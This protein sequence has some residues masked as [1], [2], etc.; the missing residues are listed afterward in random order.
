M[1][2]QRSVKYVEGWTIFSKGQRLLTA[3]SQPRWPAEH[4]ACVVQTERAHLALSWKG[5]KRGK[6]FASIEEGWVHV[7]SVHRV[8]T[9]THGGYRS[10]Q[11]GLQ[12]CLVSATPP[13]TRFS[14]TTE[15]VNVFIRLLPKMEHGRESCHVVGNACSRSC[16]ADFCGTQ[17]SF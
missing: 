11:A 12:G 5:V 13:A 2:C 14:Y 9:Q 4:W 6:N 10:G 17:S 8:S 15:R 7:C 16:G 3:T 1:S